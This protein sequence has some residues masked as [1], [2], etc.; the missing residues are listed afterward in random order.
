[1]FRGRG[2]V[3]LKVGRLCTGTPGDSPSG[4][5]VGS[6]LN[7]P[8]QQKVHWKDKIPLLDSLPALQM[9]DGVSMG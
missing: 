7:H 8:K 3:R 4:E 1:M 6:F 2:K 9:N 5:S